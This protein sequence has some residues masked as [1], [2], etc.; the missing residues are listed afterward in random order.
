[1]QTETA[2]RLRFGQ[3]PKIAPTYIFTLPDTPEIAIWVEGQKELFPLPIDN[4]AIV[5]GEKVTNR[6]PRAIPEISPD[7]VAVDVSVFNDQ[8][9]SFGHKL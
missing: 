5:L 1:L 6:F 8:I 9:T 3:K 4:E 2:S 7:R